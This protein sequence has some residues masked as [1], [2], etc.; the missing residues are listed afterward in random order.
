MQK[1]LARYKKSLQKNPISI[2]IS[3]ILILGF[4]LRF[5]N[6]NWDAGYYFHPD[7]R[8]IYMFTT[9]LEYPNSL[10]SF[11]SIESPLNP[12]FFAY[13]SLPLYLLKIISD[14]VA[15][16]NPLYAQYGGV[17]LVGR[18]ISVIFSTGTILVVY[19]LSK[20]TFDSKIALLSSFF[21]AIAVFPIQNSHFFTVDTPLTFF[22]LLTIFALAIYIKNRKL[23]YLVIVGILSGLSLATKISALP[24]IAIIALTQIGIIIGKIKSFRLFFNNAVSLL[25]VFIITLVIFV[26]TQPYVLIDF[27]NFYSQIVQQS[28]MGSD[29]FVFPYTLQYVGKIPIYYELK[30]V[31]LW[32]LGIPL[33]ILGVLGIIYITINSLLHIKKSYLIILMVFFFWTYF[34]LSANYAVGWMRYLLPIYPILAISASAFSIRILWPIAKKYIPNHNLQTFTIILFLVSCSLWTFSFLSVF[35]K[36]STRIKASEW[37]HENIPQTSVLATEHW[38][39]G[40][41]VYDAQNYTIIS[42]P[43]YDPDTEQKWDTINTQL[44]NT[45]YL[46]LA[47]NRLSTPLQKLTDCKSLPEYRC[48]PITA[49]YYKNLLSEKLGFKKVAT[50]ESYPTIPIL[51]IEINDQSADES[52]TVIDHPKIIIFKKVR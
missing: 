1:R 25:L 26:V 42:L 39:D 2:H 38:D 32:G 8:A 10:E 6:L 31:I 33:G 7:E 30:N 22:M 41:P 17:H 5:F 49:Q 37:I 35:S 50:F 29:P 20:K 52:F 14:L 4:V 12:N 18:M 24:I 9:P 40:L 43:L 27:N 51:N 44:E 11:F 16:I 23:K 48:Y 36:P 21:Y 13:G 45:D 3:L 28:K 19:L 47:S 15:F 46:I 34:L